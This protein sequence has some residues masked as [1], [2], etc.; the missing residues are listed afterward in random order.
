MF[1]VFHLTGP[2]FPATAFFYYRFARL[3]EKPVFIE[4]LPP[5]VGFV[6]CDLITL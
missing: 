4:F 2:A 5:A 3:T 6:G 1:Q